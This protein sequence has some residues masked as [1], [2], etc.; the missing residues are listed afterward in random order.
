MIAL[1]LFAEQR[2]VGV[3]SFDYH[4]WLNSYNCHFQVFNVRTVAIPYL[5]LTRGNSH[6]A[7]CPVEELE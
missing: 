4:L 5:I 6:F 2:G 7:A 3:S 1:P